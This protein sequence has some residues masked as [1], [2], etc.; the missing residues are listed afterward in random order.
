VARGALGLGG[1]S[2]KAQAVGSNYL[3][4]GNIRQGW[5]LVF[6]KRVGIW[7]GLE[8][9]MRLE[10]AAISRGIY[11]QLL[12]AELSDVGIVISCVYCVPL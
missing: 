12:H 7:M 5:Y 10:R 3:S 2:E 6:I 4:F 11:V 8:S 9:F 1:M